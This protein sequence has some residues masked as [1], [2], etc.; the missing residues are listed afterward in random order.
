MKFDHN[1]ISPLDNRYSSKI[2]DI[3][4][5]FSEYS[6]L[7]T[8]FI[9]EINW[10][11]FLCEKYPNYFS[12]ISNQSKNK[13]IKFRDSFN[14]KSVLEIKKIEKVTNHDVKAVEYYIR[15]FFK[16]DSVLKKYINLIHF[17]L[18]SEDI[19]SLSYAIMIKDGIQVCEKDLKN[20]NTSLKKLSSKW[21]KIPLLSRTHGQAASPTT[22][23]KEIKVFQTRI[24]RE[25]KKLNSIAPLAK[26]SGAVGNY[27]AL[28]IAETRINWIT[29]TNKFIKMFNVNQ[30][31]IT[32][33]IEPHD[34]IA[35]LLQSITR[36]NNICIDTSQDMWIYISN[37]IFKLKL[38][39]NEVGS[40]TMP[41]K[42]NPIDFENAEGNFGLSNSLNEY[43]INKLP[44][45]RLQRDLSDSTVLRNIG[46]S[47]GYTKIGITSLLNGLQ[48]ISPN[49]EFIFSELDNNWEVLT[50][51]VQTIMRYEGI[52]D[53]YELLKN[54]SRGKK[55]DKDSYKSFVKIREK[56][57]ER[58]L[59][60]ILY[61]EENLQKASTAYISVVNIF[62]QQINVP[63]IP[64]FIAFISI[65]SLLIN[66]T[67]MWGIFIAKFNPTTLETLFGTGP[68]QLNKYLYEHKIKLDLPEYRLQ[69]LFL[70]HSSLLD[71]VI[72]FGIF[73]F[74]LITCF[75]IYLYLYK[76][77]NLLLKL[78]CFY[79][80]IN[81]LK[82]DSI[83]Y[84]NSF[85][86]IATSFLVLY[87]Y[88][89]SEVEDG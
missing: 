70:P 62:T 35:E 18:T 48:K 41:H 73:G 74:L 14:D 32:T 11:L 30:N 37:E 24:E 58:D 67:E 51:A 87:F 80:I 34:W 43:F 68:F 61:N 57:I 72:F 17:G 20:L 9:I 45:S 76:K 27:H 19:N 75:T 5:I 79:L 33:Q 25:I 46:M 86:L 29:F 12:K 31:P 49:K 21:S 7:K 1:N 28:D 22:I 50:E 3:R 63:F 66:R 77:N 47:F 44:R 54:L 89:G 88:E 55:L 56:M 60:S 59:N 23:G 85:L 78:S 69:E 10:L 2:E 15:N 84:L 53:G 71:M 39:N 82:S 16:K 65:V 52:D 8:R 81:F 83:L 38:S 4:S 26:F 36:I 6:L 40:S 13:I 42:V 64:N